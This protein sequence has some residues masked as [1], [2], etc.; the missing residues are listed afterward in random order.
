MNPLADLKDI[1]IP[2]SLGWWP[3]AYGWWLL[4][5]IVLSLVIW[6]LIFSIKRYQYNQPKRQAHATLAAITQDSPNWPIELNS[7]LKR[8]VQTYQPNL[9]I[10]SLFGDKWLDFLTQA[11]ATNKQSEFKPKMQHF[12]Q[13]LYQAQPAK[14]LDFAES[15]TLIANWIKDAKL[16][17]KQSGQRFSQWSPSNAAQGGSDV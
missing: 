15:Q 1:H 14:Q 3:P 13:A 17:G 7:L 4:T 10:Q 8:L 16:T 2:N 5:L 12:Q 11:L 6:L 9:A